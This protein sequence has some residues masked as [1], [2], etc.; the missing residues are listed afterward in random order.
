MAT[1]MKLPIIVLCI[2]S[3]VL[4]I[5]FVSF[6]KGRIND[7]ELSTFEFYSE[8]F[9]TL[10]EEAF[11]SENFEEEI[12]ITL[13]YDENSEIKTTLLDADRN[14]YAP[15]VSVTKKA[16]EIV[17]KQDPIPVE[18]TTTEVSGKEYEMYFTNEDIRMVAKT[19]YGEAGSYWISRADKAKVAWT[20]LNRVDSPRWPNTISAVITQPDQF[21]GYNASYPVTTECYEIAKD[22]LTR[23]SMEKQGVEIYREA[24]KNITAFYGDGRNNHFYVY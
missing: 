23:W 8:E 1:K 15:V 2:L 13:E 12:V 4:T 19:I 10:G 20:I 21:H 17:L 3:V 5:G 6:E 9:Y 14:L 16:E 22:V 18:E 7:E 24:A 11:L